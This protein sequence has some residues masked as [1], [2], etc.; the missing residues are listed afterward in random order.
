ME[1]TGSNEVSKLIAAINENILSGN[2]NKK[3]IK[4]FKAVLKQM[5]DY[6]IF[7]KLQKKEN[8]S[9]YILIE[10][11]FIKSEQSIIKIGRT[12]RSVVTRF[13]EYPKGSVLLGVGH[14]N[15]CVAGEKILIDMFKKLYE[16][17][18]GIGLEYFKGDIR[19]MEITFHEIITSIKKSEI[20]SPNISQ[21]FPSTNLLITENIDEYNDY[22][23]QTVDL[24]PSIMHNFE[25]NEAQL[26]ELNDIEKTDCAKKISNFVKMI[27]T[28]KPD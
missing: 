14:V 19:A 20:L 21:T 24:D 22:E 1:V 10:D 11:R 12:I 27:K 17:Q 26:Y 6:K 15:D 5:E 4:T 2:Y 7:N 25:E 16:R 13:K 23:L 18:L 28:E 8:E 3:S 9:L